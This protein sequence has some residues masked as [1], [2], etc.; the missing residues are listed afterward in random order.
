M[1]FTAFLLVPVL[2][3]AT[4]S[5]VLV[6]LLMGLFRRSRM[7]DLPG[8]E[9]HKQQARAVPYGGGAGM[10]MALIVVLVLV[11]SI[12]GG[13]FRLTGLRLEPLWPI[14]A[15]AFLLFGLGLVDDSRPLRPAIKLLVQ[16]IAV[17]IAVYFSGLRID[18]I[19]DQPVLSYGLAA[20]WCMVVTNAFN[21]LDHADGLSATTAIISLTVLVSASLMSG[22]VQLGLVFLSLIGVLGG[23]LVWNRPPARVY[24]FDAGSLP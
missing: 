7:I 3:G 9:A 16:A 4:A 18:I 1:M 5:A 6:R 21:L 15:G 23:F 8:T 11:A 13:A 20:I 10:A 17:G 19:Q 24:M 12:A 22:D 2:I 14:A